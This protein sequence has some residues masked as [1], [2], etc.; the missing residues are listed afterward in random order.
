MPDPVLCYIDGHKAYFTT[1]PLAEQQ[2][3]DWDDAPYDLNAGPPYE[4]YDPGEDWE[5]TA[6]YFDCVL[7]PPE[8]WCSTSTLSVERINAGEAPWLR[9]ETDARAAIHAGTTLDRFKRLIREYGGKI[10]VEERPA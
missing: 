9:S 10:Y 6:V 2:G 7:T 1:R 8:Y 4:P 3:D 5:I